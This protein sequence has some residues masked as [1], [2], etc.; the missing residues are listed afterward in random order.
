[1][2]LVE[3]RGTIIV[4]ASDAVAPEYGRVPTA[5]RHFGVSQSRLY[6][7]A[8]AGLVRFVKIGTAT[9]VDFASVRDYLAS[10]PTAPISSPKQ[11]ASSAPSVHTGRGLGGAY[12]GGG[13]GSNDGSVGRCQ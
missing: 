9:L 5:C 10:C 6:L 3:R 1:V 2:R 13:A 12:G 11:G 4:D 7:L 8:A